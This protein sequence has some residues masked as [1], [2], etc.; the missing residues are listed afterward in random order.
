MNDVEATLRSAS[1]P[2]VGNQATRFTPGDG[3]VLV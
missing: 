1:P 3:K 2:M